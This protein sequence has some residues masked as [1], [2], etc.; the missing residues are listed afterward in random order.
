[1]S[2]IL[3][4][5]LLA[6]LIADWLFGEPD[7]L[8]SRFPHPIVLFGKVIEL[9]D[10][11][12]NLEKYSNAQ[13]FRNGAISICLLILGAVIV[14]Q[15]ISQ[16]LN[17]FGIVGVIIEGIIVFVFLAQKSLYNH[18]LAVADGLRDRGLRG[19]RKAVGLIV[20]R[21]PELLDKKGII[22]AGIETLAENFS[23]GVVAPAFWYLVFGLPGLFAYKMINTADSMIA[24][25]S[26]RHLHFG[27]VA[28]HIDDLANWLP[29][30]LSILF[31]AFGAF[32]IEGI[33][34][35]KTSL[36]TAYKD[37]KITPSPNAG[38]PEAAMAGALNIALGGPRT[39]RHGVVEQAYLNDEG[40]KDLLIDHIDEALEV[41]KIACFGLMG[42]VFLLAVLL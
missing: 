39:Y 15:F 19:G 10:S 11:E 25:K 36:F 14:G 31:I 9:A 5:I 3:F 22:R 7:I 27:K 41:F 38:W 28:A 26:D 33:E 18:V 20:G 1:M 23:D 16:I 8:W 42:L 4:F 34:T 37:A 24:Y 12:F 29:A 35:A 2:E 32:C 30:R 6:A 17:A 13:R 21:D 40:E